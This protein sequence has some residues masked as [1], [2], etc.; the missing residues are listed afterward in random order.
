MTE[1][2]LLIWPNGFPKRGSLTVMSSGPHIIY[3]CD[4]WRTAVNEADTVALEAPNQG[5]AGGRI[6]ALYMTSL[7]SASKAT[8]LYE[9]LLL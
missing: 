2:T 1:A 6:S 8:P 9:G 5:R 3:A 4:V 7:R